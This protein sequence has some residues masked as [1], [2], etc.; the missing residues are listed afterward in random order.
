MLASLSRRRRIG[1]V[2]AFGRFVGRM[3]ASDRA[4]AAVLAL[5]FAFSCL[6]SLIALERTVL[7]EV[8]TRGGGLVEG[9]VGNPRFVNPLLALSD[10]DRDLA[11]LTFAGLMGEGPQGLRP[12]LAESYTISP[13]GKTYT[14]TLRKG[15]KFTDGTPITADDVVFTVEKAQ[16]PALKSPELANWANIRAEAVDARTVR[17]TLPKAYGPFLEDTTLGILPSHIWKSV[18]SEQFPFDKRIAEPVGDGPFKVERV[19]RNRAG[20]ITEYD[21]VANGSYALGRPYLDRMAFKFYASEEELATAYKDGRVDSAYGIAEPGAKT[22]PYSRVFGVFFNQSA[23]K[24]LSQ[25][26]VRKALSIAIDRSALTQDILGG[27]ATPLMGPVPPGSG[28]SEPSLPSG[29]RIAQA[30]QVLTD[31]GWTY[32][33]NAK[34]WTNAKAK[35]SLASISI[36][37]SNVPELKTLS[38]SIEKDWEALGVATSLTYVDPAA[39]VSS[40]IRPRSYEALFFGMVI[41]RDQ[42]LFPFWD[43]SQKND[44]GLNVAM[45]ANKNVDALLEKARQETDPAAHANELQKISDAI[46]ADYPAAFTHAPDFVYAVPKELQGVVLPQ[47]TSPADR[48][49]TVATWHLRTEW[50]WPFLVKQPVE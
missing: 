22:A 29:D 19:S 42:D 46:A 8:P 14:F 27:Y 15:I 10:S 4:I 49:A 48:F 21:L 50:V 12:V 2:E 32:D 31:A 35:L 45:Y 6:L 43:S 9:E 3:P 30:K 41:G 37:T 24:A 1:F 33:E 23:N 18:P 5:V 7:V 16:D 39:L 44:P 47:I 17:F 40:A 28:I 25:L 13:D 11:T 20:V 36:T 34:A 26:E 38:A